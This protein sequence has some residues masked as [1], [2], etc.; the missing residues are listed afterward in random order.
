MLVR[1]QEE[2]PDNKPVV[3]HNKSAA[4]DVA[5]KDM[6]TKALHR[7]GSNMTNDLGNAAPDNKPEDAEATDEVDVPQATDA[8]AHDAEVVDYSLAAEPDADLAAGVD[9]VE[10]DAAVVAVDEV[11]EPASARELVDAAAAEPDEAAEPVLARELADAVVV[12]VDEVAELASAQELAD[13]AV[14]AVDEVAEPVLAQDL[15]G[16][17]VVV[18]VVDGTVEAMVADGMTAAEEVAVR[19]VVAE[20]RLHHHMVDVVNS[21]RL[22]LQRRAQLFQ[23]KC[24]LQSGLPE[25]YKELMLNPASL[26][27]MFGTKMVSLFQSPLR[28]GAFFCGDKSSPNY[29]TNDRRAN[30][31]PGKRRKKRAKKTPNKFNCGKKED[32]VSPSCTKGAPSVQRTAYLFFEAEHQT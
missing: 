26:F 4:M 30:L 8:V 22:Q 10:A 27:G 29:R 9:P 16:K 23:Q 12:A 11:A 28:V 17:E 2:V 1:K 13:A 6:D 3:E 15:D 18:P 25:K 19:D 21:L 24:W 7:V 32:A 31:R 5:D 20:R 14:V